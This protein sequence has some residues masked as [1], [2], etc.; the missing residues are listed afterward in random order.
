MSCDNI[1]RVYCIFKT[2]WLCTKLVYCNNIYAKI[3]LGV[4]SECYLHGRSC[5]WFSTH[6]MLETHRIKRRFP[7][8]SITPTTV[9]L[10]PK[11][12]QNINFH[13]TFE[14]ST[15]RHLPFFY[16]SPPFGA[17]TNSKSY[18]KQVCYWTMPVGRQWLVS[19]TVDNE[20]GDSVLSRQKQNF[21]ILH[22]PFKWLASWYQFVV[23]RCSHI[24][25]QTSK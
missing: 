21:R 25:H 23:Y 12:S 24:G 4:A 22:I 8:I 14:S 13:N 18:K 5:F 2:L 6:S 15:R 19:L 20:F 9:S 7:A 11:F 16:S 1:R 3:L 10:L 17:H